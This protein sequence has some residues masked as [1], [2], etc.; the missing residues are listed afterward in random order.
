MTTPRETQRGPAR[1]RPQGCRGACTRCARPGPVG[2][3][4]SP[5]LGEAHRV[6]RVLGHHLEEGC[7]LNYPSSTSNNTPPKKG[8]GGGTVAGWHSCYCSN[9]ASQ[10]AHLGKVC[11]QRVLGRRAAS[12]GRVVA[13]NARQRSR[14]GPRSKATR[15]QTT[16][17][18]NSPRETASS[19]SPGTEYLV[20][21]TNTTRGRSEL[22]VTRAWRALT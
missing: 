12:A 21:R 2:T 7:C 20:S 15:E 16:T 17:C 14:R 6:M 22:E 9:A 13:C 3:R 11:E 10:R 8:P 1:G 5:K 19:A 4:C 18:T